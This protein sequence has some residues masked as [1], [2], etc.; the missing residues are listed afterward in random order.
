MLSTIIRVHHQAQLYKTPAKKKTTTTKHVPRNFRVA[1]MEVGLFME[2]KNI[3][4]D[5]D[6]ADVKVTSGQ[7]F[8]PAGTPQENTLRKEKVREGT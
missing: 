6:I 5:D 1:T 8:S 3:Y 4:S 2:I 7:T